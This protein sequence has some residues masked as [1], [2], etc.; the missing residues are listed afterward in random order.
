M[1]L[2]DTRRTAKYLHQFLESWFRGMSDPKTAESNI[3]QNEVNMFLGGKEE[4]EKAFDREYRN[5]HVFTVMRKGIYDTQ[6]L[7]TAPERELPER[8]RKLL[9]PQTLDDWREAG[10]CLALEVPTACAFHICRGT[11]A[12]MLAYYAALA[13][14]PWPYPQTRNWDAYITHLDKKSAP[15]SITSRL[16]EI[17]E[18][19]RNA[20][21]HPDKTVTLD[22]APILFRLCTG[23]TFY[24]CEEMEKLAR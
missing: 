20:Y 17:R 14:H 21:A 18:M 9:P 2:D 1:P 8:L 6:A 22:E 12:L 7:I 19:D 13:K 16:N 11:E 15:K 10:R 5:L 3:L 23:V 4:F 24:M